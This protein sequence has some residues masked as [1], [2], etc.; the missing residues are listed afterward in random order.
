MNTKTGSRCQD[1]IPEDA[2]FYSRGPSRG[3]GANWRCPNCGGSDLKKV[4]LAYQE[5][6]SRVD[7]KTRLRAFLLGSDGPDVIVGNAVTRG[8]HQTQLSRRFRPPMKWSYL[9][10]IGWSAVVSFAVLIVYVHTVMGNSTKVS[11]LPAEFGMLGVAT[12][13]LFLLF[14]IW[15]HNHL[16][17]PRQ[18][19]EWN[20]SWL[21][22]RCGG[23]S[24]QRL[25]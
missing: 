21:C 3:R 18:Y 4:S 13:F 17:Y 10:L 2:L 7:T 16:V 20:D 12:G 25:D 22:Q 1:S 15:K 9:K 8:I 24:S 11:A 14:L 5:G 19:A 6:V 23:V